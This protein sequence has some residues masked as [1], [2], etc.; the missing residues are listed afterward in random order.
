MAKVGKR[1]RI[2]KQLR[3]AKHPISPKYLAGCYG[4][5]KHDSYEQARAAAEI[6]P[7][8]VKPYKCQFGSHYHIGR[9]IK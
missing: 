9:R 1:A 5:V 4:K 8:I 7:S 6:K 3:N 2:R